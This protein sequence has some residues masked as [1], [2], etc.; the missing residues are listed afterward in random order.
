MS[1][2]PDRSILSLG[3]RKSST[4]WLVVVMTPVLVVT[5]APPLHATDTLV[6]PDGNGAR[7]YFAPV[8]PRAGMEVMT[9]GLQR[10]LFDAIT[11]A[12]RARGQAAPLPD[13]RLEAFAAT[14]ART[15][16]PDEVP[17]VEL[18]EFLLS[19][20]G[21]GETIPELAMLQVILDDDIIHDKVR[22]NLPRV[23][24]GGP[25]GRVGIGVQRRFLGRTSV[26]VALQRVDLEMLPIPR[27]L[28]VGS[29]AM[30]AG[31][32]LAGLRDPKVLVAPPGGRE[33][34][35]LPIRT[36]GDNFQTSFRCDDGT[37]RY[38]VE[39]VGV[40]RAGKTVVA[41]F[42]VHCGVAPPRSTP[43]VAIGRPE[44]DDPRQA[45][46]LLLAAVNR[47]RAAV[48]LPALEWDE[49]L[50][51]AARAYSDE[52]AER[53]LVEHVSPRSG[54]A[55]DR[56]RRAGARANVV[57]ENVARANSI[58]DAQ[59]SF[60]SSPGHR[61]NVLS[62][63]VTRLGAGVTIRKEAGGIPSLYVTQLYA[64]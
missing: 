11:R 19:H 25:F 27:R 48:G 26:V 18:Q 51:R 33:V 50:A 52:M 41:N 17:G 7:N 55:A 10:S 1:N 46:Q 53:Q 57:L 8:P 43:R 31:R 29:S 38:Q 34:R 15:L 6:V 40:G 45:E 64:R 14:L 20:F 59:K 60:M 35:T 21:L 32:L 39:I 3:M 36:T 4:F 28:E 22:S 63:Q 5:A 42:P 49:P 30:V 2:V 44:S 24:A 61:A 13:A 62:R 47:D 56:V 12:A 9:D 54:N 58:A 37:G 23:L 16:G